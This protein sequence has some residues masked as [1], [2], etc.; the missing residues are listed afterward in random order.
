MWNHDSISQIYSLDIP[1]KAIITDET[2]ENILDCVDLA[3][4]IINNIRVGLLS[5]LYRRLVWMISEN[6][7]L[8]RKQDESERK[9]VIFMFKLIKNEQ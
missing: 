4:T 5:P 1:V 2:L 8:E 9:Y 7:G 6:C 3:T